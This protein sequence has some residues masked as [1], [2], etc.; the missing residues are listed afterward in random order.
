MFSKMNINSHEFQGEI[1]A[2][3]L[4]ELHPEMMLANPCGPV[5]VIEAD[6]AKGIYQVMYTAY[7]YFVGVGR[8]DIKGIFNQPREEFSK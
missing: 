2:G 6:N 7:D 1:L 5:L 3:D 4:I 8:I